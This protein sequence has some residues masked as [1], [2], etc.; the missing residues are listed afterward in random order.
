MNPNLPTQSRMIGEH[1]YTVTR[2]G[3]S[4]ARRLL[5]LSEQIL[6]PAVLSLLSGLDPIASINSLLNM[7]FRAAGEAVLG[8]LGRLGSAK[9][10]EVFKLLGLH[11]QVQDEGK[12]LI[13]TPAVQDQWWA[14]H[15][16]ECMAWL[17]FAYEV[18]FKDFFGGASKHLAGLFPK[19]RE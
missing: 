4:N 14:L 3:F 17:A 10:D 11:T 1:E 2:L 6:G 19:V 5:E 16:E 9:S 12:P 8:V 13:L 7:D 18:Q 15:P